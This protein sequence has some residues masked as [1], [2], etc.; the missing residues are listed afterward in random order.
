MAE[1]FSRDIRISSVGTAQR[2]V[3][4]ERRENQTSGVDWMS[5]TKPVSSMGNSILSS[6]E[7]FTLF[8]VA[9]DRGGL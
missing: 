6:G 4:H 7:C 2:H 9:C 5:V 1:E 3:H 8:I